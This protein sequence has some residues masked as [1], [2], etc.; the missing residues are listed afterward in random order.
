M[1]CKGRLFQVIILKNEDTLISLLCCTGGLN[2]SSVYLFVFGRR[3]DVL[4]ELYLWTVLT[5]WTGF[6]QILKQWVQAT[7]GIWNS[8]ASW[9]FCLFVFNISYL[10]F[11]LKRDFHGRRVTKNL[12]VHTKQK[13]DW[14]NRT[15]LKACLKLRPS[16]IDYYYFKSWFCVLQREA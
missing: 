15:C 6:A 5:A 16:H 4:D 8:K 3:P 10:K 9:F 1:Q 2:V 7:Q 13:G 14:D 11:L 12:N